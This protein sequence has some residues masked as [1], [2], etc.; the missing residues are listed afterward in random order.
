MLFNTT[1]K[2]KDYI[3]E[4]NILVGKSFSLFERIKNGG[5][6]SSRMV[7]AEFSEKLQPK[8]K[9]SID[10]NYMN[11]ELRPKGIIVHFTN[12]L[13]RYSWLIPYFRLVVYNAQ[14]FSIHANGNYI[15]CKKNKNYQ[16]NKKF[17]DNMITIKNNFL[18]LGY[19]DM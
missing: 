4:S 17:I 19:Y 12:K 7:V 14:N 16:N 5:I 18:N 8:N 2:N 9:S 10:I 1:H 15:K 11:I 3:A 6:G 13:D